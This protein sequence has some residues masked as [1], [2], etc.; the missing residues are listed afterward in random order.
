MPP[1]KGVEGHGVLGGVAFDVLNKRGQQ[2]RPLA[3]PT[4]LNNS[5]ARP[6]PDVQLFG[7]RDALQVGEV[8]PSMER[9][10]PGL[11]QF[12]DQHRLLQ[13]IFGFEQFGRQGWFDGDFDNVVVEDVLDNGWQGG[14][15]GR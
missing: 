12:P 5:S 13:E 2:G 4:V 1:V 11:E 8:A 10:R 6:H 3:V 15:R 7:C 14:A 9:R